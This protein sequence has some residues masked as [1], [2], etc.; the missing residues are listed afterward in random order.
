MGVDYYYCKSCEE[1][2]HSDNFRGCDICGDLDTCTKCDSS[3]NFLIE[4]NCQLCNDCIA[5]SDEND[6]IVRRE[7]VEYRNYRLH[8]ESNK[9]S[10]L[11]LT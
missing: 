6:V 9:F 2:L 1:C 4:D 10:R 7:S 3:F 11:L 5:N 8:L